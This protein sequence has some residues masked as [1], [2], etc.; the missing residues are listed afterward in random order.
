MAKTI[1]ITGAGSGIGRGMAQHLSSL[2]HRIVISDRI[3]ESAIE[4]ADLIGDHAKGDAIELDVTCGDS[5]A[6]L[7][8]RLAQVPVDVLINNAGIQHVSGLEEF[9][10]DAWDNVVDVLLNG[11]ARVTRA[12]LPAMRASGY[13]RIINIGS[14]HSIVASPFKTAY[15]AAKHGLLGFSK[16]LALETSDVDITVNTV[17]PGYVR[18]PLVE[19]QIS[20]QAALH[21]I[22]EEEV[23]D[24]IMLGPMPKGVFVTT[25]EMAE[26]AQ[27]LMSKHARNITG[28]EIVMDGGWTI[29]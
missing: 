20:E 16:T 7:S 23:I 21:H 11:V 28:Q 19:K 3:L 26:T 25:E 9:P 17:C 13:G 2:G 10:Q 5:I 6:A 15:V 8:D 4:T 1:L 14:I 24:K 18:T 27:F 29:R 22:S 12:C